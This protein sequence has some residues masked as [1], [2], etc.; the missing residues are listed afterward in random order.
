[1]TTE[2][3]RLAAAADHEVWT[4]NPGSACLPYEC[5][6]EGIR[7]RCGGACC[8]DRGYWPPSSGGVKR[9]PCP[10]LTIG[11]GCTLGDARPITCHLYPLVVSDRGTLMVDPDTRWVKTGVCKGNRGAEGAPMLIDAVRPG[12]VALFGEEVWARARTTVMAGRPARLVVPEWLK[13]ALRE[14]GRLADANESPT[15]R[16]GAVGL[17]TEAAS[18]PP[19]Q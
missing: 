12:L 3:E 6:V 9:G 1:M 14:E 16:M 19:P 13:A 11:V 4:L 10:A 2:G 8:W 15:A 5:T 18:Q 17:G 7:D